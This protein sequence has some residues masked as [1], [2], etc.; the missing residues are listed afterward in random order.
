MCGLLRYH[1]GGG[2][3]LVTPVAQAVFKPFG[4]KVGLLPT[5]LEVLKSLLTKPYYLLVAHLKGQF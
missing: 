2:R 3:T 4:V 5:F 1:Q